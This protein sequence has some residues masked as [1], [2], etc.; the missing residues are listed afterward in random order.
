[1]PYKNSSR[2][3]PPQPSSLSLLLILRLRWVFRGG[4]GRLRR[5]DR[6][7]GAVA[8]PVGAV[9]HDALTR[10]QPRQDRD[11]LPVARTE[12]DLLHS[13]RVLRLDDIDEGAGRAAL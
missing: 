2:G 5:R 4:R 13:D 6:D 8:Q 11:A 10:F 1:M 7:L 12:L 9:D 3:A